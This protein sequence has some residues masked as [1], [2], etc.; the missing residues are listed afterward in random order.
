MPALKYWDG[1]AWQNITGGGA[2][3]PPN[4][5]QVGYPVSDNLTGPGVTISATTYGTHTGPAILAWA[6]STGT[7]A[8]HFYAQIGMSLG[9]VV[10]DL[11]CTVGVKTYP[12]QV[13]VFAPNDNYCI[14]AA[15]PPTPTNG[16]GFIS[17]LLLAPCGGPGQYAVTMHHRVTVGQTNMLRRRMLVL[18][19]ELTTS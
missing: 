18:P 10:S 19:V 4:Y 6:G 11:I 9:G 13:E 5:R 14:Y 1:T 2:I 8:V 3:A 7:V 17:G 16:P 15:P 12:G